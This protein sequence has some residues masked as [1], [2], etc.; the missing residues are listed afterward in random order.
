MPIKTTG[1]SRID[2]ATAE[3]AGHV[4]DGRIGSH[5]RWREQDHYDE[6][7]RLRNE[8]MAGEQ[9]LIWAQ[10][11]EM[12]PGQSIKIVLASG[13]V[14]QV[15]RC[16]D[17]PQFALSPSGTDGVT[18]TQ[19]MSCQMCGAQPLQAEWASPDRGGQ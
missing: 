8:I 10:A 19:M 11:A 17:F 1:N 4:R 15:E 14:I 5:V 6:A 12:S 13:Q 3:I 2:G 9:E 16:C 18:V 7:V